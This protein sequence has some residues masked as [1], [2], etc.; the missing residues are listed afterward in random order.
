MFLLY[1]WLSFKGK[2]QDWYKYLVSSSIFS[3]DQLRENLF[4]R[5]SEKGDLSSLL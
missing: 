1:Y 4:E 3:W 5:F 2:S